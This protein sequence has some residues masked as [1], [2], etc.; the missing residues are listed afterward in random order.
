MVETM[1]ANAGQTSIGA[2]KP[3]GERRPLRVL[4]V[5]D[6]V[7]VRSGTRR[8]L[9]CMAGLHVVGEAADGLEAV[10]MAR[11]LIPDLIIMDISMPSL[12]GLEATR[13]IKANLPHIHVIVL[14][15]H[16]G[17]PFH[18]QA[19]EAGAT[20]YVVKGTPAEKLTDAVKRVLAGPKMLF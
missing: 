13:R 8:L 1:N 5:D 20:D 7:L 18:Q 6:H 2:G 15:S 11:T 9:G 16:E 12:D 19:L 17:H 3:M 14:S 10:A 4:I